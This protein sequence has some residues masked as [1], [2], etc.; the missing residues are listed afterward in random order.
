[1]A[2][3]RR[4]KTEEEE[5]DF[6]LPKFDEEKFLKR[7]RRNIKTLFISFLLGLIIAI[8]SFGFWVLLKDSA[9]R[10]ELILLLGVFNASWIRYLYSRLNIDLTD[11]GK[12]GWFGTYATY[13]FTWLIILIILEHATSYRISISISNYF[14]QVKSL[15]TNVKN[16]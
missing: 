7:E 8:I 6:K 5:T 9:F 1:M 3:K 12:K 13:F 4:E 15:P 10:W 11:F 2:K 14:R 16:T